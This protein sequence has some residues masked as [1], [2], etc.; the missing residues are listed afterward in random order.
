MAAKK[1]STGEAIGRAIISAALQLGAGGGMAGYVLGGMGGRG[2]STVDDGYPSPMH[3][4]KV[5][6]Q[7][8]PA[9][10]NQGIKRGIAEK[11]ARMQTLEEHNEALTKY[12]KQLP[13]NASAREKHLAIVKGAEEEAKLMSYWDDKKP[14]RNFS[15][16]SSAVKEIRITPDHRIQVKW[17]GKPPKTNPSGWYTYKQHAN[18]YEASLAA[19]RLLTSGSIGLSVYPGRG[20]FS[21]EENDDSMRPVKKV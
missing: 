2:D 7:P 1:T 6:Y 14:R 3:T 8:G 5:N 20:F 15:P 9:R 13:A 10:Y 16:S 12:L 18:A 21:K 19:Q 4:V 17:G 11:A